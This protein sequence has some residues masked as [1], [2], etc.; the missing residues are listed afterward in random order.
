MPLPPAAAC[1]LVRARLLE[2]LGPE[3]R[4]GPV[5]L[6]AQLGQAMLFALEP[7]RTISIAL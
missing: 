7:P 5:L 4:R 3:G 1:M 6:S 2:W